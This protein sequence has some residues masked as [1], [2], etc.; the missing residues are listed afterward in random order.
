MSYP[1]YTIALTG[2]LGWSFWPYGD[3]YSLIPKWKEW[4]SVTGRAISPDEEENRFELVARKNSQD[5]F[6]V[7]QVGD[8]TDPSNPIIPLATPAFT[9]RVWLPFGYGEDRA[10]DV[11]YVT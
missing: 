8:F 7:V 6:F 2:G 3:V 9:S 5:S 10:L 4:H 11:D 1:Q